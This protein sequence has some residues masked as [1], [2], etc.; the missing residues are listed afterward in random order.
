MIV[1]CTFTV[2][3]LPSVTARWTDG[4]VCATGILISFCFEFDFELSSSA[5]ARPLV[6]AVTLTFF[7]SSF[8][9]FYGCTFHA[10]IFSI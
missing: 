9:A 2:D 3:P 4:D 8:R 10:F 6:S 1:R 5:V 7:F